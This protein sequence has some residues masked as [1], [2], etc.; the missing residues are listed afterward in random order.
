MHGGSPLVAAGPGDKN[1]NKE[2]KYLIG[3]LSFGTKSCD[4]ADPDRGYPEVY[5]SIVNY[6][7]WIIANMKP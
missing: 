3:I 1:L 2:P 7:P 5:T 6:L 4:Q